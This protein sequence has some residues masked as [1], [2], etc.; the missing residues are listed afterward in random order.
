MGR[1][2]VSVR[3]CNETLAVAKGGVHLAEMEY[4][5]SALGMPYQ[6]NIEAVTND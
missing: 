3:V 4:P 1:S 5:A 2:L 6:I